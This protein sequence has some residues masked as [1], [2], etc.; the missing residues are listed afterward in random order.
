MHGSNDF[1]EY[2]TEVEIETRA[3]VIRLRVLAVLGLLLGAGIAVATGAPGALGAALA[4]ILGILVHRKT[5]SF[6]RQSA[7]VDATGFVCGR[8]RVPRAQIRGARVHPK[9]PRSVIIER[10]GAPEQAIELIVRDPADG[11]RLVEALRYQPTDEHDPDQRMFAIG[12][13]GPWR[14]VAAGTVAFIAWSIALGTKSWALGLAGVGLIGWALADWF[15]H[16]CATIFVGDD[17][18]LVRTR[19]RERFVSYGT[20]AAVRAVAAE[21]G[22]VAGA[23]SWSY[24]VLV[25]Q[26]GTETKLPIQRLRGDGHSELAFVIARR[27]EAALTAYRAIERRQGAELSRRERSTS[28]WLDHLRELAKERDYRRWGLSDE[29]LVELAGCAR[30]APSAR[31]GAAVLMRLRQ[32]GPTPTA[33]RSRV[34]IA[35]DDIAEPSLRRVMERI[36]AARDD[37]LALELELIQDEEAAVE[38][39][40]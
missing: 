13:R 1:P 34:R 40:T 25:L 5:R 19:W 11:R 15:V 24:L 39:S 32:G 29:R 6:E 30:T 26:D 27:V 16:Q 28:E 2:R 18:L 37:E 36:P 7:Q 35:V 22:H 21:P 10:S 14:L 3:S 33:E 38:R 17:G 8:Y 31:A 12:G 20:V 4:A 9:R 23:T